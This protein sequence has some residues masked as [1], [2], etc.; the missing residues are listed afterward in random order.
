MRRV[1]KS[2]AKSE[3]I[4]EKPH[5]IE[6]QK[7]SYEKFLQFNTPEADRT[8]SGLQGI[9]K[10]VFPIQ[11]FNGACSLEFVKYTFG[12]PKYTV[13]EC[14][15]RGMT[16][17]VPI[18]ITVRLVSYELDNDGEVQNVRDIKEQEVYLGSIPLMT[19]TGVF[20]VNGTE[21]V[22][23]SQLQRSPGLFY[24]HDSGKTSSGGKILYSARIIPVRG[25]WIDLEFDAKDILYVRI[26]RRRKF[27]VTTL[28]K[29]LGYSP[30]ELL[31]YYYGIEK[32]TIS[33][34]KF[35]KQ[36]DEA[37][38]VGQRVP[39]DIIHPKTGEILAKK[40]RKIGKTLASKIIE[41]GIDTFQVEIDEIIGKVVV[42]D[43]VDPKTGE[44][45]VQCNE[46]LSETALDEIIAAKVKEFEVLYMDGSK[47]SD[48]FHKTLAM[49][50]ASTTEEALVEIY[51]RLRPSS[52]PTIEVATTFF[53]NLFFNPDTYDLSIVG[54]FKIN[55]RLNVN[56]D[57]EI[58]TLNKEDIMLA[59]RQLVRLKDSQGPIDD[60]DHLG[61]RRVRTV[62]ELIENQYRMGLVR[63][64]RAIRE[65]MSLQEVETLMPHDLINP[66]PI[67]A[68]IKE[69]FGTSQ[70]SQ[71][72]DQ[73]N[74]LSEVTHKRRLSALGPG[75]LSRERAGFEVRDVHPTHY[76]RIC[77]VETPEGPNI[78][79]IVSLAAYARVNKYGFIETPY[80]KVEKRRVTDNVEFMTALDEKDFVIAPAKVET[81]S[82]GKIVPDTII[83][84]EEG[85][86]IIT[87]SDRITHQDVSPNQ[88]VSVA[89]SLIPFLENDDANRAL[90]GS[91][92]QRQGVPLLRC[93]AP[94]VGTG[95]ESAVA[96]DSGVCLLAGGNG[97]VEEVDA[98][99]VVVRYQ[100]PGTDGFSSGVGIYRLD[101]Y[102]KSNQNTCFNQ[103]PVVLPGQKISKGQVLADG[104][105][106]DQGELALGKNVTIAFMPWR[107]FNFEDSILVSERLLKNDTYTSV[108]IEVFETVARDTKLGKEEI[109]RDIPNVSEE[110]LRNLDDSGVV[111]IG[112]EV[113]PGDT[114][115]GKVTPKGETQLSPEEKLLRAIFGEKAGDVKDTSL[116]V[117][118]GVE[119]FVI[120][121]K[122]FS[123][124]GVEKDERAQAIDKVEIKR[125]QRDLDDELNSLKK[126]ARAGLSDLLTGKTVKTS[127]NIKD[128]TEILAKGKKITT[129]VLDQ[130][131]LRD[132]RMLDYT[133]R[134]KLEGEVELLFER[135]NSQVQTVKD[136]YEAR[137]SRLMKGDDLPPGV[138]KMVKVYVAIKRKLSVGDK[139]AGRHGN[140][141]VVSRILPEEDMPYFADGSSVDIVLNPLGVPSRMN[142]GQVL[143]THLGLAAMKL[144]A[145]LQ[146]FAEKN[147]IK[148]LKQL[149]QKHYSKKEYE[150]LTDGLTDADIIDL[151]RKMGTGINMA[152]PVFD[153]A[154]EAEIRSL[155]VDSGIDEIGQSTL[156]DGLTGEK[157]ENQ[158]TY[159][160]MYMMKLHHLVDNKIHARSTGPYSLV[161]QQPLGGKAQFGGQRLGEMEVWAM[162]AYGAAYTLKEFLTVKSDD[163]SGRTKMYEKIV[164]GN[165]FLEAG[166]PE[167]FHVLV[168]ELQGLCLDME[169]IDE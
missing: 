54:R 161:T 135:Y 119:G 82:K 104:P 62:G 65:R 71:F 169:L 5:L 10:S 129:E 66:K 25:S 100:E 14:V 92:M 168:K 9:F 37:T 72:M 6:M 48:S 58:S 60:I 90:M 116:R 126:G 143:E 153:G 32:I 111:R 134:Q 78:G 138:I 87:S 53:N 42:R 26:D 64:E 73:T 27:P 107:G 132:I 34:K 13:E 79:L 47:V 68:A 88:L 154:N 151:A 85:E 77:P 52:P 97:V 24:S 38:I 163:V 2:F 76:G 164:K 125:L 118:P 152:T 103:K 7:V 128:G 147:E 15:E 84:R 89:A 22:I 162:E 110:S 167:S 57:V 96:R 12:E 23:V 86:V 43:L 41:A 141:G 39:S 69:F 144:G 159:G 140:K 30:E 136:V 106:C 109:T 123:R 67:T 70:L 130:M 108:H 117:P 91:N 166:L 124:K 102:R 139:M 35:T 4:V 98:N 56:I 80:R 145:R 16:F 94:L 40:N 36:F 101:K 148:A 93:S 61:N 121:A 19:R 120:D 63:M 149:L 156:F 160:V 20:V 150:K 11:D 165:N 74:P 131:P 99:R 51:R 1:R 133:D 18:K 31:Q 29:A 157:F 50:K 81:N 115:V 105:A 112:A 3:E 95:L 114:L 44:V 127:V 55:A 83:A 158:V 21:R 155:L 113:N 49:D 137:I 142:V 8:D 122:V 33:G 46:K 28:L 17:E 45:I 75:G 59:V 146:V